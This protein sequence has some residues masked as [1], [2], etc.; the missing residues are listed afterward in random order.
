VPGGAAGVFAGAREGGV[1]D[2]KLTKLTG[3]V[4][5][6]VSAQV[7]HLTDEGLVDAEKLRLTIEA[8]REKAKTLVEGGMSERQ[9]AAELGV[10]KTTVHDDLVSFRPESGQKATI[11]DDKASDRDE[12]REAAILSN[13]A[14]AKVEVVLPAKR[15]ETIV[16]DPPWPV[17]KIERDVRPNQVA[18]DYPT[19]TE[20][21]L[22]E[23]G[24]TLNRIAADDCHLLM[25]TTQKFSPLGRQPKRNSVAFCV[26]GPIS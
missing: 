25:W 15:Y 13:E 17:Q 12:R 20:A 5:A 21:E 22:R 14:L 2:E 9:A 24:A 11:G 23:F 8:R 19:M 7:R 18:F 4:I 6:A 16:V 3:A 10:S 26:R 1:S